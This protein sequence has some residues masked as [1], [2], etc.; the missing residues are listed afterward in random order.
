MRVKFLLLGVA[1]IVL[2][3]GC[4]TVKRLAPPGF[5]KYEDLAK[6]TPPNPTIEAKIDDR[7]FGEDSRFPNLSNAPNSPPSAIDPQTREATTEN[8]IAERERLQNALSADRKAAE[9]EARAEADA[10]DEARD[11]LVDAIDQQRAKAAVEAVGRPS[12]RDDQ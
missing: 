4:E 2:L 5:V 7:E 10:L 1:G 9:A 6:D 3:G 8:L 12:P 11:A